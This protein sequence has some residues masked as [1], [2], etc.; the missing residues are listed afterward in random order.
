M[1]GAARARCCLWAIFSVAIFVP[2]AFAEQGWLPVISDAEAAPFESSPSDLETGWYP[3]LI[4]PPKRSEA[5]SRPAPAPAATAEAGSSPAMAPRSA[6][7]TKAAEPIP[8][9]EPVV[10]P[11][12]VPP[13]KPVSVPVPLTTGS[14]PKGS[15]AESYCTSIADAAADARFAWQ[16][17]TLD[18]MEKE[19]ER[20]IVILEKRTT[21]YREWL[22]RR[23]AFVE[24]ARESLVSIYAQ[25][26]PD[27]AASQ[28]AAM[29]QETAAAVLTKLKPR[30]ASAILNE[31]PPGAA[32]RLSMTIAGAAEVPPE[33]EPRPA[34]GGGRS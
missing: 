3:V 34:A 19:L 11:V 29:D 26:R 13:P 5:P 23:D 1:M 27:A 28:L 31:M 32:A 16:K 18:E 15:L 17:R 2:A 8:A 22:A 9:P 30:I 6:R 21:E 10:A 20:R 12:P 24:K 33:D 14:P 7:K 25:M 4:N